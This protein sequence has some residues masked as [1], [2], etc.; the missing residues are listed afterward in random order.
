MVQIHIVSLGGHLSEWM[1]EVVMGSLGYMENC[2]V[3]P[4]DIKENCK[5]ELVKLSNET[6]TCLMLI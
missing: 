1:V 5:Y 3:I 6:H 2:G 4:V